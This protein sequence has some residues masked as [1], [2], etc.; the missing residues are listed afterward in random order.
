MWQCFVLPATCP[1]AAPLCLLLPCSSR[2]IQSGLSPAPS[3]LSITPQYFQITPADS[4]DNT[5]YLFTQPR[6]CLP[7]SGFTEPSQLPLCP[8]LQPPAHSPC[9]CFLFHNRAE[10]TS[11][12]RSLAII[13]HTLSIPP[14]L[15][16]T[17]T[18]P[19]F[20]LLCGL[21]GFGTAGPRANL[22]CRASKPA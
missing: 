2:R 19:A 5:S 4:R 1:R 15:H 22:Q 12:A 17:C 20:R 11:G 13:N 6:C 16:C 21:S 9:T 18:F 8:F 14:R 3:G 10:F 7:N